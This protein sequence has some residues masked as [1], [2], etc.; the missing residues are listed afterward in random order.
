MEFLH[1][2]LKRH[3]RGNKRWRH[4]CRLF[5]QVSFTVITEFLTSTDIKSSSSDQG[6]LAAR[7]EK[8]G[9]FATTPLEFAYLHRKNRCEMLIG[10]DDN[11]NDVIT[12]GTCFSMLVYLCA[13]FRFALID[14]NLTAQSPGSHRGMGD[15]IPIPET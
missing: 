6:A 3:F 15:G 12:L 11:S 7:R 14:G 13:R 1:S 2:F 8:E 5:S 10:G 4:H 9:E